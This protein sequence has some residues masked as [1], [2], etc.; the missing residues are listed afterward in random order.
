M[1]K[2]KKKFENMVESSSNKIGKMPDVSRV[3]LE[4]YINAYLV[5]AFLGLIIVQGFI[6]NTLQTVLFSLGFA[7]SLLQFISK[8]N[9]YRKIKL[10]QQIKNANNK[11]N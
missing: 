10:M 11:S 9:F 3:R 6:H 4:V 8:S 2:I 5:L 1:G 7:A